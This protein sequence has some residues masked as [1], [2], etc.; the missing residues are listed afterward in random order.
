MAIVGMGLGVGAFY[1]GYRET[2]AGILWG[3]PLGLFNYYLACRAVG[4]LG[5]ERG[6][7]LFAGTIAFR[8]ALAL[9]ALFLALRG[10]VWFLLGVAL[11]V[12]IQMLSQLVDAVAVLVGLRR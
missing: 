4:Y 8:W 6:T 10:G 12:E 5:A 2:G 3:L 1:L 11:G 7:R 9:A